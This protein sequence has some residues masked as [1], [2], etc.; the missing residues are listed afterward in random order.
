MIKNKIFYYEIFV[1]ANRTRKRTKYESRLKSYRSC[2]VSQTNRPDFYEEFNFSR[3]HLNSDNKLCV[4]VY[5][6]DEPSDFIDVD[7][8]P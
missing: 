4:T 6:G 5:A 2:V 1:S 7:F 3:S 8:M